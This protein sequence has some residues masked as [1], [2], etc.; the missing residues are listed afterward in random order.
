MVN[1]FN[2]IK[3]LIVHVVKKIDGASSVR[4]TRDISISWQ[5]KTRLEK[6]NIQQKN[7]NDITVINC[8]TSPHMSYN[9]VDSELTFKR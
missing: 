8:L 2:K 6:T 3:N 4:R 9:R 5:A 7:S 1:N